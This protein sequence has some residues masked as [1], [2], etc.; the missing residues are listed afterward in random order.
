VSKKFRSVSVVLA[1]VAAAV[2]VGVPAAS[3]G[4]TTLPLSLQVMLGSRLS[5]CVADTTCSTFLRRLVS[6]CRADATCS[7]R[8]DQFLTDNPTIA[9]IL[10]RL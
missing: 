10:A 7:V 5:A 6:A 1:S 3:A 9:A 2:A 8:L 4:S